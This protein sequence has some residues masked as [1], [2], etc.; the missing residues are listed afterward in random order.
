MNEILAKGK[1]LKDAANKMAELTTQEKNEALIAI[2]DILEENSEEILSI[3]NIDVCTAKESGTSDA[4]IDRLTLTK[5]RISEITEA[6]RKLAAFNDP[7]GEIIESWTAENG[8]FISKVR[9]PIGA[10]GM[11][12]E[13]RPNVTVDAATIA[14]KTGNAIMLRGSSSTLKSNICIT[15]LMKKALENTK[16]PANAI[17]LIEDP[18]YD[19]VNQMLHLRGYLDVI[20][21]RGGASLIKTVTENSSVPVIETGVGNCHVY[22]DES[23]DKDMAISL[24]VNSKTQRPS[25]CNAAET[26]L[27]HK[28]WADSYLAGLISEL[29]NKGVS[30][31]GCPEI[32]QRFEHIRPAEES[33]I[34]RAHV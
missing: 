27:V 22:I 23:A 4:L 11:I 6:V 1:L 20:I 28:T 3:N 17:Q 9:V 2:A 8:I 26:L 25:V 10:V 21:P 19:S 5:E 14:L 31:A 24:A 15:E 13:A 16:I 33:E 29:S 12:Y 18:S 34:G 7:I 32:C 30:F